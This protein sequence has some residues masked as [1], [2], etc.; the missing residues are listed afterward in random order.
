MRRVASAIWRRRRER[1]AFKRFADDNHFIYFGR[2][3]ASDEEYR[4]VLGLSAST[5]FRDDHYTVGT[6]DDHDVVLLDRKNT[7]HS[8]HGRSVAHRWLIAEITLERLDL[9]HLFLDFHQADE[10]Y[11]DELLTTLGRFQDITYLFE[12]YHPEFTQRCKV[13]G[14]IQQHGQIADVLRPELI[15]ALGHEHYQFD[16]EMEGHKLYVYASDSEPSERLLESMV[17]VGLWFAAQLSEAAT[18]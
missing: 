18:S 8:S 5:G 3:T 14:F 12:G 1:R 17:R 6:A 10:N 16:Y 4:P 2:I 7:V 15:A 9:P 13:F 11:Y